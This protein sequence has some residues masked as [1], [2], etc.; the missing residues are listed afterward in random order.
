MNPYLMLI[1]KN[2]M[3]V[4]AEGSNMT[5]QHETQ[6]LYLYTITETE[7][8]NSLVLKVQI[9]VLSPEVRRCHVSQIQECFTRNKSIERHVVI[10]YF[11]LIFG[12]GNDFENRHKFPDT[13][14][15]E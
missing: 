15:V 10:G 3:Y 5:R 2:W 7:L 6:K 9:C 1:K 13:N 12:E 4:C 14:N 11:R 8:P